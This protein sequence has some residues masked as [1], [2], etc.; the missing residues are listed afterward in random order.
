LGL[1]L[2]VALTLITLHFLGSL[3]GSTQPSQR[4]SA[5]L[6]LDLNSAGRDDLL[7]LPGV[8]DKLAERILDHQQQHGFRRIEDLRKVSGIG[9]ALLEKLRP[10]VYV[11]AEPAY[12]PPGE[13]SVKS[14]RVEKPA[15][16]GSSRTAKPLPAELIDINRAGIEELQQLPSIGPTLAQ[17]I[18]E[19]RKVSP[20]T[21]VE[22]L[23]RVPGIGPKTLDKLRPHVTVST[24]SARNA[25]VN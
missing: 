8:G 11:E 10:F 5:N 21:S 17:R 20:F 23:R 16:S 2:G 13:T 6:Y 3:H 15:N 7:Q 4:E 1:L 14:S 18:I 19:A 22:D 24:T 9:P 25:D 12:R